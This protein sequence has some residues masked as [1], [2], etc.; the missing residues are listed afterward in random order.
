[1]DDKDKYCIIEGWKRL[2][3][4]GFSPFEANKIAQE[5]YKKVKK[6]SQTTQK[7]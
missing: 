5:V 3:E 6:S 7:K 2:K 4:K 1:M